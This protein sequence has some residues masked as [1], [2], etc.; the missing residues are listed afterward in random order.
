[1]ARGQGA[2]VVKR[3]LEALIQEFVGGVNRVKS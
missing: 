1:M 2:V 3:G